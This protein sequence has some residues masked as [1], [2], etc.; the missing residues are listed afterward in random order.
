[1]SHKNLLSKLCLLVIISFVLVHSASNPPFSTSMCPKYIETGSV[2][3]YY[4]SAICG[5]C[6]AF[7][8]KSNIITFL[9][10]KS[11]TAYEIL[12]SF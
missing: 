3:L 11:N 8:P 4:H 1:M 10:A 6:S 9:W 2:Y 12:L 7:V 5:S